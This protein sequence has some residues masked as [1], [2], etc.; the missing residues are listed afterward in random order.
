[1]VLYITD[2]FGLLLGMRTSSLYYKRIYYRVSKLLNKLH[3]SKMN[4]TTF[5]LYCFTIGFLLHFLLQ[6]L[7]FVFNV[8]I[9]RTDSVCWFHC[10]FVLFLLLLSFLLILRCSIQRTW[11]GSTTFSYGFCNTYSL[12]SP[13]FLQF[14]L[15]E[16]I[17]VHCLFSPLSSDLLILFSNLFLYLFLFQTIHLPFQQFFLLSQSL[18]FTCTALYRALSIPCLHAFS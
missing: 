1:M 6:F 11:K 9:I 5:S 2:S 15:F 14:L 13:F 17:F 4:L 16:S 7:N 3:I 18:C 8:I 12:S 10:A